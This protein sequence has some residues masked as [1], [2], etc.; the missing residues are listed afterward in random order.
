[1]SWEGQSLKELGNNPEDARDPGQLQ[2]RKPPYLSLFICAV[3]I[4]HLSPTPHPK[5]WMEGK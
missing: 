1:M 4:R 5:A 3:G 2:G